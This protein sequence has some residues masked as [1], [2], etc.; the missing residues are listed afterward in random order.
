MQYAYAYR[1][2]QVYAIR[3][4][5]LLHDYGKQNVKGMGN[6][7][8]YMGSMGVE[9]LHHKAHLGSDSGHTPQ[10]MMDVAQRDREPMSTDRLHALLYAPG[11][12]PCRYVFTST[13]NTNGTFSSP[14]YPNKYPDN[15]RCHYIF[16]GTS[17]E[18]I[19]LTFKDF[20]LERASI[21]G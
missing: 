1:F 14:E 9:L 8:M 10:W 2:L 16:Q 3:I 20:H 11:A 13:K 21:G 5:H 12:M 6:R 15:I 7:Y 4:P 17:D 18:R 19:R